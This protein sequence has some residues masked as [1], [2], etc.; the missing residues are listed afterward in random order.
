MND[1]ENVKGDI[2]DETAG[3]GI[4]AMWFSVLLLSTTLV[5]TEVK[6]LWTH[7]APCECS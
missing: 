3:D 5:I 1:V 2:E 6:M 4:S 7:E